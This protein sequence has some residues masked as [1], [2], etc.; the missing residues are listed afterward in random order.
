MIMKSLSQCKSVFFWLLIV[1]Y[2]KWGHINNFEGEAHEDFV[3]EVYELRTLRRSWNLFF[4]S[5]LKRFP[6]SLTNFIKKKPP[7]VSNIYILL[8]S[9]CSHTLTKQWLIH[10]ATFPYVTLLSITDSRPSYTVKWTWH[11]MTCL[12]KNMH[13]VYWDILVADISP[14][15]LF[16][17]QELALSCYGLI[18]DVGILK[19]YILNL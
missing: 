9:F 2:S 19:L 7:L 13:V 14:L 12:A 10:D 18:N 8:V 5:G 6:S 1:I 15:S 16:T 17:A 11:D 4:I 3:F